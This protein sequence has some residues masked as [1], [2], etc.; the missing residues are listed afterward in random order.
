MK[1]AKFVITPLGEEEN[2]L[3]LLECAIIDYLDSKFDFYIDEI[4]L[5]EVIDNIIE[6]LH[7]LNSLKLKYQELLMYINFIKKIIKWWDLQK[8]NYKLEN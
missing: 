1:K 6:Y 2:I 3:N 4:T 5:E 8:Y 7:S